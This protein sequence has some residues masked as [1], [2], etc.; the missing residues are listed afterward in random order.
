[1]AEQTIHKTMVRAIAILALLAGCVPGTPTPDYIPTATNTPPPTATYTPSPTIIPTATPLTPLE[2]RLFFDMNGSGLMDE[3]TFN[4]DPE[5]LADPRQPLQPDLG[6]VVNDYVSAHPDIKDGDLISIEEPGLSNYTVCVQA[7]C[8][9]TDAQGNFSLPI[10][11]GA[12]RAS[13]QIT[14]PNADNPALAMRYINDWKGPVVVPAYT[15]DVD[16]ATMARLTSIPGCDID[17]AALVCK[18]NDATLQVRDQHLNDTNII[19]IGDGTYIKSG[20]YNNVGLMQGFLT[21][22]FV[23]EQVPD[24]FFQN[25]FDIYSVNFWPDNFTVN[26]ARNGLVQIYKG[27]APPPLSEQDALRVRSGE[28]IVGQDDAHIGIDFLVDFASNLVSTIPTSTVMFVKP[29]DDYGVD[30]HLMSDNPENADNPYVTNSSHMFFSLV[31][32]NQ[33][34]FRGQIIGLSGDESPHISFPQLHF[35][36]VKMMNGGWFYL[37]PFRYIIPLDSLPT[38]FAGSEVSYWT[39]DNNPQFSRI[40]SANK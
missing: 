35:H 13:I 22:P 7:D 36:L 19:P 4:Y 2:G 15:K 26:D 33:R 9:Q 37:D 28:H 34:V 10:P 39:S 17:L 6:K 18:L 23:S 29:K 38:P 32:N 1:M 24:P 27:N 5:R 40:D 31:E 30:V 11:S 8:V 20:A 12:S 14:D 21:L 16:A 25:Y 3:A